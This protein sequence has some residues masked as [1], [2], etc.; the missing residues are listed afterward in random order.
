MPRI[1]IVCNKIN[2]FHTEMYNKHKYD[3]DG[4][5]PCIQVAMRPVEDYCAFLS[6]TIIMEESNAMPTSPSRSYVSG[7]P[8]P[9]PEGIN[10]HDNLF[11]TSPTSCNHNLSLFESVDDAIDT[12][13]PTLNCLWSS[14]TKTF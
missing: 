8:S 7:T 13:L 9:P 6:D 12:T 11:E 1:D 4:Q 3:D 10:A 14:S 2:S 5:R